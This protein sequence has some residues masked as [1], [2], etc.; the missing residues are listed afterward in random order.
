MKIKALFW[1]ICLG[2][3]PW[4]GY[5]QA[6]EK[7]L[8]WKISGNGLASPSYLF[9]TIHLIP[10]EKFLFSK[11]AQAAFTSCSQLALEINLDMDKETKR[12]VAEKTL[13]PDGKSWEDYTTKEEYEKL[14]RYLK[15][16]ADIS[17]MMI[18][19]YKKIKPFYVS[20]L[21]LKE[22]IRNEISYE[23]TFTDM[24]EKKKMPVLGLETILDQLSILDSISAE[25][26]MKMLIQSLAE[27]SPEREFQRLLTLYL[28]QDLDGMQ[29]LV[30]SESN[31]I[32]GF[33][34][35]FLNE[36]NR[37]W[38]PVIEK[39]IVDKPTFIAVGAAHL[40]GEGGV[41]RLLRERGYQIEA[42]F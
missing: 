11:N 37:K 42:I 19:L 1:S 35:L 14:T 10:E 12:M 18:A 28:S 30:K 4:Q 6:G 23:E 26:Q 33:E 41:I 20:G 15:D 31:T 34:N 7:S 25:K 9:G 36:R 8:C 16:S 29:S 21:I 27:S 22:Q 38:I 2:I 17:G 3:I 39:L 24:A 13:L 5:G 32:E 40:G